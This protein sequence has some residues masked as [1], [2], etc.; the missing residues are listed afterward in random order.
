MIFLD[1]DG[2]LFDPECFGRLIRSK[3]INILNTNE[4]ELMRV[5]ADYY[6]NLETTTDFNPRD[7]TVF[8][9]QRFG[10]DPS[11]LDAVF[12]EDNDIYRDSL[13]PEV[14]DALGSLSKREKLGIF[15][16]GNEDLQ[17]RKLVATGL[18]KYIDPEEII[19]HRRKTSD[20]ALVLLPRDITVVDDNHDV[21]ISLLPIA[22]P[23]WINRRSDEG[24]PRVRTIH[25]LNELLA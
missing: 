16:Q 10:V 2:T 15:S 23:V 3:F 7:I 13:Y 18:I 5:I 25:A 9:A 20:E 4:E 19:I 11:P 8:I 1:I 22:Q 14:E 12:W 6:A 21:V 24:D 17:R